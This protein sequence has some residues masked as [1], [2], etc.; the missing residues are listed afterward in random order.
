MYQHCSG[1]NK[2]FNKWVA[3]QIHRARGHRP[4]INLNTTVIAMKKLLK[5]HTS[6]SK[7][8]RLK[9][10]KHVNETVEKGTAQSDELDPESVDCTILDQTA[11]VRMVVV[12]MGTTNLSSMLKKLLIKLE[13]RWQAEHSVMEAYAYAT[14]VFSTRFVD[15]SCPCN[16]KMRPHLHNPSTKETIEWVKE[17][18]D[19]F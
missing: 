2:M 10:M 8:F 11:K 3:D 14:V 6:E 15:G 13:K 7:T 18:Y 5:D 19:T 1:L 9:D 12:V 16:L 4:V 17:A